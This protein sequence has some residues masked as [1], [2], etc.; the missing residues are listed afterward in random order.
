MHRTDTIDYCLVLEGE[1]A[2]ELDDGKE[3]SLKAGDILVQRGTWH[4]WANRTDKPCRLA[5]IL[6]GSKEPAHHLHERHG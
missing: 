1:C 3:V 5:F 2:M 4:G 6:I